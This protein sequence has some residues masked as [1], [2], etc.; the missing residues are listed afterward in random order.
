L[1]KIYF[2]LIGTILLNNNIVYSQQYYSDISSFDKLTLFNETF[3]NNYNNWIID[4]QWISGRIANGAMEIA[5]KNYKQSTGLSYKTVQIDYSRDFEIE[6]SLYIRKGTGALIFGLD[7]KL[8]HYRVEITDKNLLVILKNIPSKKKIEKLLPLSLNSN[9]KNEAFNN[10]TVRKLKTTLYVFINEILAGQFEGIELAGERIGFNVG[11]DSE[12]S[13]DYLKISY[14]NDKSNPLIAEDDKSGNI[15]NPQNQP[16]GPRIVWVSPTGLITP[17]ETYSARVKANIRSV[18]GIKSVLIYLNGV[19]KG[20]AEPKLIAGEKGIYSVERIIDFSPGENN[21][22]IVATDENGVAS[23][24][25]TRSF[26]NPNSIPP[27]I[28][29]TNPYSPTAVARSEKLEIE[30]CIKTLTELKSLKVFVNGESQGEVN[31]FQPASS[32]DCN[33]IWKFPV[34]LKGGDNSIYVSATNAAGSAPSEKRTVKLVSVSDEK[35][36]ALVIGNSNYRN[37]TPLKNPENDANLME[38]TLKDLGF[39]VIKRVNAG[40]E[41]MSAAIREFSQKLSDYDVALFYYAGH[42]NQV[43]QINYMIPSD[44]ELS[45]RSACKYEAIR[46]DF[47]I[48]EF[49]KYSDKTNIVIL[50]A[51]RDNPYAS[52]SRGNESGFNAMTCTS[53]TI[54]AFATAAGAT[55][56]DGQGANGLFTE[57]LVKQITIPQPIESVFK[58]TRVQVRTRSN[59]TQEP[60]EYSCLNDEFYFVK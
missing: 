50:D 32:G 14:F 45:D 53:G 13:V 30:V 16:G 20:E 37:K 48:D 11:L 22:Y 54:I 6:T 39:D 40:K 28:L 7:E 42:G 4:N 41:V 52:W 60:A 47:V 57:E 38:A 19:S 56:A 21:V 3:E 36:L 27:V 35:R 43:D 23:R 12:I 5:C 33:Y 34:F 18:S 55:A 10:I 31:A 26:V 44:A 9:I 24:S 8:D 1:G 29:W 17:L 51:C 2:F 58:R 25:E 46:V 59:G 15:L 49:K